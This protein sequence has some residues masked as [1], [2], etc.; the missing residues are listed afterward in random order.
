M[1]TVAVLAFVSAVVLA[2]PVVVAIAG[3]LAILGVLSPS[4][5]GEVDLFGS[6]DLES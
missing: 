2:L 5:G 1:R 4:R 3:L 6:F